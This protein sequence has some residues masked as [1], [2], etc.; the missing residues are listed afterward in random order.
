M[1]RK[2]KFSKL[3]VYHRVLL[4]VFLFIFLFSYILLPNANGAS[5]EGAIHVRNEVELRN[6]VNNAP[7]NVPVAIIFDASITLTNTLYIPVG[8]LITLTCNDPVNSYLLVGPNNQ[9]TITVVGGGGLTLDG[10]VVTHNAGVSGSGVTV[11]FGG[12]LILS[13]GTISGN[14]AARG[15]GVYNAGFFKMIGGEISNNCVFY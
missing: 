1:N 8:K 3:D 14:T 5:L 2:T 9:S 12:T 13:D 6:A 10:I 15:G 7:S 11:H 4:F